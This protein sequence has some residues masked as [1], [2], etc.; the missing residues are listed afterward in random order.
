[1]FRLPVCPHCRTVYS[2]R[3][4]KKSGKIIKCYH[5]KKEFKKSFLS[6]IIPF[7]LTLIPA[8]IINIFLLFNAGEL[9]T[10]LTEAMV[11][12]VAAVVLAM[13]ISPFFTVYKK[14]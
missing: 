11:V 1:M 10:G 7:L 8:F 13:V 4:V 6:K 12:S 3:E 2:Y 9:L 14:I 5:C